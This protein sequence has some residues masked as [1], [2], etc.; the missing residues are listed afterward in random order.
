MDSSS[1][2]SVQKISSVING[3]YGCSSFRAFDQNRLQC[4]KCCCFCGILVIVQTRFYH[5]DVPVAEFF[6]DK[7]IHLLNGNTQFIFIHVLGYF[8]CQCIDLGEDPFIGCRSADLF[9]IS[10]GTS[11]F[12]R[13]IMINLD[14][15]HTLFAKLR[16]ASTRSM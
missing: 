6:P 11:A 7:I 10:P 12:S 5:L 4:P 2:C 1:D 3:I 13:F 14:A 16:L 8:F 9:G 15:F